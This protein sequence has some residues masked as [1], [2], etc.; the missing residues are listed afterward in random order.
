MKFFDVLRAYAI[1]AC[2]SFLLSVSLSVFLTPAE[3]SAG[4]VGTIGTV[5]Y[6]FFSVPLSV[7]VLLSNAFL[8]AA[9]KRFLSSDAVFRS[10]FGVVASAVFLEVAA[11]FPCYN[12]DPTVAAVAGGFLMGIGLGLV[13]R[14]GA[15]T[16]GSDFAALILHRFFPHIPLSRLILFIDS[17]II[18]SAGIA[19]RSVTAT[20]YSAAA[21]F[22]SMEMA[23]R[24]ITFGNAAK[25]V[26]ILSPYAERI[27]FQI[28][29]RFSRG[30]T[31]IYS[32]GM[33]TEKDSLML[34]SVVS[35]KELPVLISLI[36]SIDNAAFI[37]I[38]DIR[39]VVGEGFKT[40]T[41]YDAAHKKTAP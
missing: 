40:G 29:S 30:T 26:F 16:G 18:L 1:I 10:L 4:G 25:A 3:L 37:V 39:E 33:Y 34:L 11:R 7:T 23:D 13:V 36:R 8:F 14:N 6:S 38:S 9:G 2:G 31:G 22:L 41:A 20:V 12:G 24:V 15:S 28:Q 19:F 17:I 32:R 5:L 21:L 35:P 27:S